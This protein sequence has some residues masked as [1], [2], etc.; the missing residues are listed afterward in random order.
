M[1]QV[2]LQGNHQLL[3]ANCQS[4]PSIVREEFP[5]FP[6]A[7]TAPQ[8]EQKDFHDTFGAEPEPCTCCVLLKTK[9]LCCSVAKNISMPE[10][11]RSLTRAHLLLLL[12]LSDLP[13]SMPLPA[14]PFLQFVKSRTM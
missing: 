5:K 3:I 14:L 4:T 8:E 9:K 1:N 11:S 13:P 12:P 10:N 2:K 6:C 7:L